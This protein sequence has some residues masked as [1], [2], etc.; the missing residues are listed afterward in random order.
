AMWL[1]QFVQ[2]RFARRHRSLRCG[3]GRSAGR[4]GRCRLLP[5]SPRDARKPGAGASRGRL[6]RLQRT[7]Q[8]SA[9]CMDTS[10]FR[11]RPGETVRLRGRATDDTRPFKH[12]RKAL[13]KL[14]R[15]LERL[16]TLQEL[17]YAENRWSLLLIFQ[18]MDAAG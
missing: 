8:Y 12:K 18:G 11:V 15:G 14:K 1:D 3:A 13:D 6:T 2:D 10:R 4:D 7:V 5:G 9:Y 16:V 17:L